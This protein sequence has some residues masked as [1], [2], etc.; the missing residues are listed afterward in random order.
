MLRQNSRTQC[1]EYVNKA[2]AY[3]VKGIKDPEVLVEPFLVGR[4]DKTNL[5][6]SGPGSFGQIRSDYDV[7]LISIFA[8]NFPPVPVTEEED[9]F[10]KTQAMLEQ[11]RTGTA[12]GAHL[13]PFI[14]SSFQQVV[15][16]VSKR[17]TLRSLAIMHGRHP[18]AKLDSLCLDFYSSFSGSLILT[19]RAIPTEEIIP[20]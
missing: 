7:T 20:V 13:Q 3:A 8:G 5:R 2:I 12:A 4:L 18:M 19:L 6:I 17:R 9:L 14:Q 16:W 1:Y 15:L 11:R 10:E